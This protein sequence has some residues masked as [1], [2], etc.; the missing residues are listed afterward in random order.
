MRQRAGAARWRGYIAMLAVDNKYRKLGIGNLSPLFESF[1]YFGLGSRLVREAL[2]KMVLENADEVC[3]V[4]LS[5][6]KEIGLQYF[7]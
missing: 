5:H 1:I 6:W 7:N 2:H 3:L 4:P